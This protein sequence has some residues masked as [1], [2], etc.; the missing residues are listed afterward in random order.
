MGLRDAAAQD[1]AR[2]RAQMRQGRVQRGAADIVEIEIHPLGA[3]ARDGGG[4]VLLRLV[5]DRRVSAE[6]ARDKRALRRSAGDSRHTA[7]FDAGDLDRDLTHPAR[8]G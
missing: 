6:L 8:S 3:G 7:A 1:H 2:A 5:V 4:Q